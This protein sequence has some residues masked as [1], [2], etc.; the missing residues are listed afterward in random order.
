MR[1]PK[2]LSIRQLSSPALLIGRLA[3]AGLDRTMEQQDHVMKKTRRKMN[4]NGTDRHGSG[5]DLAF[6][7]TQNRPG[8]Q[9][10]DKQRWLFIYPPWSGLSHWARWRDGP[11]TI[12]ALT[13]MQARSSVPVGFDPYCLAQLADQAQIDGHKAHAIDLIAAIYATY[14]AASH[15]R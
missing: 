8:R 4:L 13:P 6:I 5:P 12:H 1:T 2:V 3:W 14:D 11:G 9:S 7:A 15:V 10:V